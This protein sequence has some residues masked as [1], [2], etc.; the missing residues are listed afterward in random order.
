MNQESEPR[1]SRLEKIG[2][3]RRFV[4]RESIL[5]VR[6]ARR[7]AH[8]AP[9]T[10]ISGAESRKKTIEKCGGGTREKS[11]NISTYE[12]R[13]ESEHQERP[14]SKARDDRSVFFGSLNFEVKLVVRD[15]APTR[16]RTR[17]R[18]HASV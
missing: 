11:I 3:S 7:S 12:F 10:G 9:K 5:V 13:T 18:P 4:A 16:T 2:L 15:G 6:F 1:V 8:L 17:P 14:K